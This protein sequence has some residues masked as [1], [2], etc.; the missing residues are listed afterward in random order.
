MALNWKTAIAP[1][2]KAATSGVRLTPSDRTAK[3]MDVA[4]ADFKNGNADVKRPVITQS[5]DNVRF[6]VRFANTALKLVGEDT[7]FS[8]PADKFEEIYAAIRASVV[9]GEF[10]EQLAPLEA[11][12][13]E[14]GAKL[15]ASRKGTAPE[16]AT[17]RRTAR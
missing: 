6:S 9:A 8:A 15:S 2:S 7:I 12:V 16:A 14:R 4:L 3:N 1:V 10:N 5:G 17:K 11:R 13:A